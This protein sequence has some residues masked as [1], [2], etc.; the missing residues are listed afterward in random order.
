[1]ASG[2]ESCRARQ[3]S[4]AELRGEMIELRLDC[5]DPLEYVVARAFQR[6][7]TCG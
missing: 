4:A 3:L 5:A 2:S 1:V 7:D 6:G